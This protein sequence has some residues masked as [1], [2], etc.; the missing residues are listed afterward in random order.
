MRSRRGSAGGKGKGSLEV[1]EKK[2]HRGGG[3]RVKRMKTSA[4][5]GLQGFFLEIEDGICAAAEK[6]LC[7]LLALP[8]PETER[9]GQTLS[10]SCDAIKTQTQI[11]DVH[12]A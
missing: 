8:E 2:R 7:S 10:R 12:S 11:V 9:G 1:E 6:T 3:G 4:G 5:R